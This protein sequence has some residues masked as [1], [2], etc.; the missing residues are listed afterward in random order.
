MY[1]AWLAEKNRGDTELKFRVLS[2]EFEGRIM[3]LDLSKHHYASGILDMRLFH[4]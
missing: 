4:K 3:R 1:F 2:E